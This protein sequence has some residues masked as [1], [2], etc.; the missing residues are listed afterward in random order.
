MLG[1]IAVIDGCREIFWVRAVIKLSQVTGVTGGWILGRLSRIYK[2]G[3][4]DTWHAR[5]VILGGANERPPL[6]DRYGDQSF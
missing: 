6:G 5:E 3:G 2:C 4:V 1:I